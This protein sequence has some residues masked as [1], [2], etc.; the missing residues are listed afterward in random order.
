MP[1]PPYRTPALFFRIPYLGTTAAFRQRRASA[2]PDDWRRGRCNPELRRGRHHRGPYSHSIINERFNQS[3]FIVLS[4]AARIFTVTFTVNLPSASIGAGLQAVRPKLTFRDL[5]TSIDIYRLPR[6][7][8]T[9]SARVR[10]GRG[11]VQEAPASNTLSCC[12]NASFRP[13]F[14]RHDAGRAVKL[15]VSIAIYRLSP[16]SAN[17]LPAPDDPA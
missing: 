16:L 13:Y 12:P 9:P 11:S 10:V 6:R 5:S 1:A 3:I 4:T 17:D 15:R 2:Y 7:L 8:P 14:C